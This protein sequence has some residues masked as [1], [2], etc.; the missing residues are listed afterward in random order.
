MEKTKPAVL[1]ELI[2][3]D[4]LQIAV[5]CHDGFTAELIQQAGFKV[6]LMS[7]A[8]LAGSLMGTPDY[9]L[10]TLSEM[11]DAAR[12]ICA[13]VDIPVIGDGDNGY[14][15]PLNVRRAV[16]EFEAAGCAAIQLEDQVAPK[17]CGHM[18]GKEVVPMLEHCRK[19]ET[20]RDFRKEMLILARSDARAT[21]GIEEAIHRVNE[22]ARA[23]ADFVIIDA[24]ATVEELQ[25]I[26]DQVIVP[27]MLNQ[28][29]GGKTPI[30]PVSEL[31]KM[32]FRGI[33]CYPAVCPLTMIHSLQ[34]VLAAL[35]QDG[36]TKNVS[37]KMGVMKDHTDLVGLPYYRELEMKYV[38]GVSK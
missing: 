4:E 11:A 18:E 2:Y 27:T 29:E 30:L 31:K 14:G 7:G 10:L 3:G 28:V 22:Y 19:I 5:G 6:A 24:P 33:I 35:L 25:M 13:C 21:H 37:G 36:T 12:R 17:K 1:K 23:G 32:G 8:G 20:A 34:E 26:A 16:M 15:N 38:H 9:G